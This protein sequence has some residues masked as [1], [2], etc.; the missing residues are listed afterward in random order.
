MLQNG[1]RPCV[2]M[3]AEKVTACC[4]AMPTSKARSG[5]ASIMNFSE[6]PVGMAGVTPTMRSSFSASSMMVCPKTS[7][8]FGG[9]GDLG[10]TLMISPVSL[11]NSPGACH[12]VGL[13][14]SAGA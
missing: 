5:M 13:P 10:A 11:L 1:T 14:A 3:P 4:S 8:Y 2:A 6:H 12:L 9:A 7:W